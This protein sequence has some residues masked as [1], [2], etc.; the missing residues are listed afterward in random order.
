MPSGH[1]ARQFCRYLHKSILGCLRREYCCK[2]CQNCDTFHTM[3]G[4][5]PNVF[6][7]STSKIFQQQDKLVTSDLTLVKISAD[8]HVTTSKVFTRSASPKAI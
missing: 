2:L 6:V 1:Y 8:T 3:P 7:F 4:Q 5:L